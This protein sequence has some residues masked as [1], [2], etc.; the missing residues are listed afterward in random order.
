MGDYGYYLCSF[1]ILFL[2]VFSFIIVLICIRNLLCKKY[3]QIKEKT[4]IV[5]V[6]SSHKRKEKLRKRPLTISYRPFIRY[7]TVGSLI[8]YLIADMSVFINYVTFIADPKQRFGRNEVGIVTLSS[9]FSARILLHSIFVARLKYSFTGTIWIYHP[10]VF[11][12]L[13]S[14]LLIITIL[15][16][17]VLAL[18]TVTWFEYF[19]VLPMSSIQ[20]VAMPMSGLLYVFS[21][22]FDILLMYLYQRR[23]FQ[24]IR[25]YCI[26]FHTFKSNQQRVQ[27]NLNV[28]DLT[29]SGLNVDGRTHTTLSLSQKTLSPMESETES[30]VLFD[31]KEVSFAL[32]DTDREPYDETIQLKTVKKDKYSAVFDFTKLELIN[33]IAQYTILLSISVVALFVVY[34]LNSNYWIVL[35]QPM[36]ELLLVC[37]CF[38]DCCCLYSHFSFGIRLYR[39]C[40]V[41]RFCLHNLCVSC[42]A[43]NIPKS[44]E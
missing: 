33:T 43:K 35:A 2:S 30:S 21:A 14:L 1:F 42:F 10:C 31:N 23:L 16:L 8:L 9:W 26:S 18:V 27:Q 20:T 24:L 28:D 4:V 5:N 37:N 7:V 3:I 19:D 40:C 32:M 44:I 6:I 25:A 38:V 39:F 41:H 29:L 11:T 17:A 34:A 15:T 12:L 36:R 22:T 13:Y